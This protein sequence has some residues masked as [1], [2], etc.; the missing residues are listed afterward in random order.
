MCHRHRH[1]KSASGE[2]VRFGDLSVRA[3]IPFGLGWIIKIFVITRDT[4]FFSVGDKTMI[5]MRFATSWPDR[6][7]PGFDVASFT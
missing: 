1:Q 4:G 6:Q 2:S 5:L 3:L 7:L